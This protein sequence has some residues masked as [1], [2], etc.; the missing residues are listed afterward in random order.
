M[1]RRVL[2]VGLMVVMVGASMT[3]LAS[4]APHAKPKPSKAAKPKPTR[5]VRNA[6]LPVG[7]WREGSTYGPWRMVFHGFGS[8][9]ATGADRQ[10]VRLAPKAA[11][12]ADQTHGALVT[13][14]ATTRDFDATLAMATTAQLRSGSPANPWERAWAL[15]HYTDPTHF[16]YVVL[17]TNGWEIGKADPAY[18]GAQRFLVTGT[19]PTYAVGATHKITIAQRGAAFTVKVGT[20]TLTTFTDLERPYL[21][22]AL[23]LYTEDAAVTFGNVV[24]RAR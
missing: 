18:P 19:S 21:S 7:P 15:W 14:T 22:G 9:G 17:K 2:C 23:G 4:A 3:T 13:T 24:V 5:G 20:Q 6:P 1:L 10:S 8:V 11:T 16:Y 12:Q